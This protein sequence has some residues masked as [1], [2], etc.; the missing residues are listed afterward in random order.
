MLAANYRKKLGRLGEQV[1]KHYYRQRGARVIG[2]NYNCHYG[3][4]DLIALQGHEIVFIEVKTR[5]STDFGLPEDAV[6]DDK[7][8]RL[9]D[10]ADHWME[11][12]GY[13]GEYRF[14]IAA[15]IY[16]GKKVEI[17]IVEPMW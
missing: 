13:D 12:M 16:K 10:A 17:R 11:K 1:T 5:S 14:E 7:L 15:V 9:A 4:I 6:S 2:E 3:E 8:Q